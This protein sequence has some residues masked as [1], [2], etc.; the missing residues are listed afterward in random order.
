MSVLEFHINCAQDGHQ[1]WFSIYL[2]VKIIYLVVLDES[3]K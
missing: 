2:V 1:E 3:L